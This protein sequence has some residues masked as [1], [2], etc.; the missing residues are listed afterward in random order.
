MFSGLSNG[1]LVSGLARG[2]E[3]LILGLG[4]KGK[5][6]RSNSPWWSQ[7]LRAIWVS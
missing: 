4:V 2:L 1:L 3:L 5:R 7:A 6:R